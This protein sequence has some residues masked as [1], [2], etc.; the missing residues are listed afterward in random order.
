[1]KEMQTVNFR[2]KIVRQTVRPY[3]LE[4]VGGITVLKTFQGYH[5]RFLTWCVLRDLVVSV[6]DLRRPDLLPDPL[7]LKMGGFRFKQKELLIAALDR[8]KSG[9]LGAPTRYGK[10]LG[11]DVPVMTADHQL[12]PV[13]R[14]G[15]GARILGPDGQAY[16]ATGFHDGVSDMFEV[17]AVGSPLRWTC[18]DEHIHYLVDNEGHTLTR[19]SQEL[20]EE[21]STCGGWVDGYYLLRREKET[22]ELCKVPFYLRRLGMG[23][24][25]GFKTSHPEGLF[26]LGDGTVTHNTTLMINTCRAFPK[27][28]TVILTPGVDLIHQTLDAFRS[29]IP[30]REIKLIGGGSRVK[31]PS[32]DGIT[33]CSMDSMHKLDYDT[34]RLVLVDEPHAIIAKSRFDYLPKF[35]LARKIGMGATLSG[36]FDGKDALLEGIFG[37]VLANRTYREALG[38]GAVC[39]IHVM[40][41]DWPVPD[42]AGERDEVF[43]SLLYQ[44]DLVGRFARYLSTSVIPPEWQTLFFIKTEDQA[45]FVLDYVGSDVA[46]AMA[47]KLSPKDRKAMTERVRTNQIKR[48]ICSDI[49]VQGV[50]FHD[51]MCLVNLGGG[52][53]STTT[54]QK[55]GRLAEVRPGKTGA[56]LFDLSIRPPERRMIGPGLRNLVNDSKNRREAYERIGYVVHDV[57]RTEII[58]KFK[59]LALRPPNDEDH[60]GN[61]LAR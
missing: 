53:A 40:M 44:N 34:P 46:V 25:R 36:R 6:R 1:M 7:Y 48:V 3:Q 30:D 61:Q 54:I 16:T 11:I 57:T 51:L 33:I 21:F 29:A 59:S 41:V 55:P 27:A 4:K 24:W 42:A 35:H 31:F 17:M 5:H 20:W 47:K 52:G 14:L 26:V 19:T 39:Q 60:I 50:T 22:G 38:E 12:V 2:R 43:A 8:R 28:P 45:D 49:Y 18:N 56:V 10:C 13:C 32:F 37:P 9:L 58:D 15:E 23:R